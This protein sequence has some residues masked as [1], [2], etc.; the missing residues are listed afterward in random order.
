MHETQNDQHCLGAWNAH[1]ED[2]GGYGVEWPIVWHGDEGTECQDAKAKELPKRVEVLK[3][4]VVELK[5]KLQENYGDEALAEAENA[6]EEVT[7]D[8]K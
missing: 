6:L 8:N 3:S 5:K 2:P 4:N 7:A 1:H